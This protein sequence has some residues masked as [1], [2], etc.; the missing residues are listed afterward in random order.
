MEYGIMAELEE[1]LSK[2]LYTTAW[3]KVAAILEGPT[4]KVREE[5][6]KYPWVWEF[7]P[8]AKSPSGLQA[9]RREFEINPTLTLDI[10]RD[11]MAS[12]A[13]QEIGI[14]MCKQCEHPT[15]FLY[16]CNGLRKEIS[17]L[18]S[19]P[20]TTT[21]DEENKTYD[22]SDLSRVTDKDFVAEHTRVSDDIVA[23]LK[24]HDD[25]S[26]TRSAISGKNNIYCYGI[27]TF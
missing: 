22:F 1:E 27:K 7:V 4:D 10:L 2:E 14:R 24:A 11:F 23:R 18:G 8:P 6:G 21:P 20:H 9:T 19:S 12:F 16:I 26:W 17:R 15:W 25:T 13:F 5:Y 3:Y